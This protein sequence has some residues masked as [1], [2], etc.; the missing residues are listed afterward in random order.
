MEL[1]SGYYK[2]KQYQYQCGWNVKVGVILVLLVENSTLP[3]T[4]IKKIWRVGGCFLLILILSE[5]FNHAE[6]EPNPIPNPAGQIW[7]QLNII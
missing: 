1:G 2:K 3:P 6:P 5:G 7:P 4:L